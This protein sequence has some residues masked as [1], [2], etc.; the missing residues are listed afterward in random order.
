M[1]SAFAPVQTTTKQSGSAASITTT[2]MNTISGHLFVAVVTTFAN[3]ISGTPMSDSKSNSWTLAVGPAGT[4]NGFVAIYYAANATG[5][6]AHT[7]TFTP[8]SSDFCAI[9]VI[10]ITGAATSSP[11]NQSNSAVANSTTH[12][13]SSITAGS[14]AEIFVGGGVT[15]FSAEGTPVINKNYWY[16]VAALSDGAVEGIVCAW[17]AMDSGAS[18]TFS[19]TTSSAKNEG[20][21]IAG[22]KAASAGGSVAGGSYTFFGS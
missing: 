2:A 7:F 19:Y 16:H 15:S 5:G 13:T 14:T 11:L 10:E 18:D 12:A 8:S 4:T 21:V 1:A 20:V 17:R 9:S 3:T 6:A 22:F